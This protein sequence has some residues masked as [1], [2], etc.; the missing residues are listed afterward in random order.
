MI[1]KGDLFCY[2]SAMNVDEFVG[3]WTS[4]KD[5][6]GSDAVGLDIAW[7][8]IPKDSKVIQ[9]FGQVAW[10][11]MKDFYAPVWGNFRRTK[12]GEWLDNTRDDYQR[13]IDEEK[14]KIEFYKNNGLPVGYREFCGFADESG[15]TGVLADGNH[16]YIDCN[17][18]ILQGAD[19]RNDIEEC[20]L[21]VLCVK[22][23]SS[24]LSFQ[25]LP[26]K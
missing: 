15:E 3:Q 7:P 8:A 14:I 25:D 17:Y 26:P 13:F 9:F 12:L 19:I 5:T 21:D 20:R 10:E 22:E 16:R 18:L 4:K 11:K 23:L 24:V 6:D 2:N 1:F